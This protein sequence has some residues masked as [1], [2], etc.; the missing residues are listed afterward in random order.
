MKKFTFLHIPK[1]A[2]V[3]VFHTLQDL[4]VDIH[5]DIE[6][7]II[8]ADDSRSIFF[9]HVP[10]WQLMR[11]NNIHPDYFNDIITFF[12]L[13]NVWDRFLSLY[14]YLNLSNH[15]KRGELSKNIGIMEYIEKIQKAP[16]DRHHL[17]HPHS[18]WLRDLKNPIAIP[19]GV[20]MQ[21]GFN[22][23]CHLINI[24]PRSLEHRNANRHYESRTKKEIYEQTPGLREAVGDTYK[25]DI[26]R[27]GQ[28]FPY[29]DNI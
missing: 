6:H 4:M 19:F 17:G 3:S 14:Y 29:G 18:Y 8:A 24:K 15:G 16:K 11:N 25:E 28:T 13:R 26:D 7:N 2:G 9:G 23:V 21:K 12:I 1:T 5:K 22:K 27:F 10:A 20:G